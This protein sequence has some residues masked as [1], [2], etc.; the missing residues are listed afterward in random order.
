MINKFRKAHKSRTIQIAS[1]LILLSELQAFL[2]QM[3]SIIGGWYN[4]IAAAIG[5]GIIVLRFITRKPLEER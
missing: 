3:Q 1:V 2:P 5:L 4:H